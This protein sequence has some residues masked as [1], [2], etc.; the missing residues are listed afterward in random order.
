MM[1]EGAGFIDAL[2]CMGAEVVAQGLDEVG[3][4]LGTAVGIEVLQGC[5]KSRDRQTVGDG[6]A[7][8]LPQGAL[9]GVN[10]CQEEVVE[11][12]IVQVR[13]LVIGFGN[14]GQEFGLDDAASPE[15]GSNGAVIE[16]PVIRFRRALV[17]GKAL[18]ISDDFRRIEALADA[19]TKSSP[20]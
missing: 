16:V 6:Q 15:N 12:E 7:D 9:I 20:C 10:L 13:I 3:P 1:M 18:G 4:D 2:E 5:R 11:Q 19:S 14:L 8:N 17:E